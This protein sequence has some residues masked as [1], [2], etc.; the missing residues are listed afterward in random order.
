MDFQYKKDGKL[1]HACEIMVDGDRL[2]AVRDCGSA[3][4]AGLRCAPQ[5]IDTINRR[6]GRKRVNATTNLDPSTIQNMTTQDML[7]YE[8]R[9][10]VSTHSRDIALVRGEGTNPDLPSPQL[11]FLKSTSTSPFP[12][13]IDF[14]S[15]PPDYGQMDPEFEQRVVDS[16]RKARS[17]PSTQLQVAAQATQAESLETTTKPDLST[18]EDV[19]SQDVLG[20]A[21]QEV[22]MDSINP[23]LTQQQESNTQPPLPPVRSVLSK[24]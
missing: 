3:E 11:R 20:Y 1:F 6:S 10:K 18:V 19:T 23:H 8:V 15:S 9:K 7:G 13:P 21:A 24:S 22:G 2:A 4:E 16:K 17:L 14:T 5:A 12:H